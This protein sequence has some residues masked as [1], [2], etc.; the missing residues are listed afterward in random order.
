MMATTSRTG[1]T[2]Q[3]AG[4]EGAPYDL[5]AARVVDVAVAAA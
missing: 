2:G 3:R 1:S 5:P 4:C